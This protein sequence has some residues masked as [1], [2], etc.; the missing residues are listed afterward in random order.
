[1]N[2]SNAQVL[3]CRF[4]DRIGGQSRRGGRGARVGL[5][6]GRWSVALDQVGQG[7]APTVCDRAPDGWLAPPGAWIDAYLAWSLNEAEAALPR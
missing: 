3:R 5:A 2:A 6:G 1:M 4:D 7:E